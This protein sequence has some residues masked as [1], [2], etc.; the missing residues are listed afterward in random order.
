MHNIHIL[1]IYKPN[2]IRAEYSY[3]T[4]FFISSHITILY[5]ETGR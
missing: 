3:I 1:D 2:Y 5:A 4:L